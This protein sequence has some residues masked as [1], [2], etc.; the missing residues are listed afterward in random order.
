SRKLQ[1]EVVPFIEDM[2]AALASAD[3]VVSR[4]GA[5]ALSE[6][7]AVGRASLLVPY[8]F[9][10]GDH[11]RK[12]ADWLAERGAALCLDAN[13]LS[14]EPVAALLSELLQDAPRLA[15]LAEAA[16]A[17]GRPEAAQLIA[18]DLLMLAGLHHSMPGSLRVC[19]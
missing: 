18:E 2:Q 13:A 5:S 9:A 11:Q 15:K 10:A 3:L 6:I 7:C 12:N 1:F 19:G 14:A 4:S 8:P 17:A 16:R